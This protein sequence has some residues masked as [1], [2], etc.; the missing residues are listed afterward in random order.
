MMDNRRHFLFLNIG[1]FIDHFFL[2]IF[3]TAAA[4]SL[5]QEWQLSY[6]AL[7]P[8]STAGFVAFG[9]FSLPSG[10][11]ADRWSRQGMMFVFFV[12][13]GLSAIGTS[14]AQSPF[15][16]GLWLFLLG[17]F[18]SIY[19]PV[20]LALIARGGAKMGRDIA[21]NGVW[22]NMGVG[23][24]AFL[25]GLMIDQTGWRSAFWLP[26]LLSVGVG[27]LYFAHQKENI[28]VPFKALNLHKTKTKQPE[29]S[30]DAF[31]LRQLI[32][33]VS[34]VIFFTTAISSVIFQGTTFA[35]PKI[36]E[37]RLTGI[38][39]S[40]SLIGSLALFVFAIASFAQIVVGRMLDSFGPKRVFLSV[41]AIQ[42]VFFT[43][44][45]GQ[46]DW[47][48]L[49][50]AL[51]FM[52]GAFGQIPINDYMVGKMAKSELRASIYGV[53]YVISFGVWAVVVPLIS[54]VHIHYG[55]DMLFY[56]LA[57]CAFCLLA[58][59]STLPRH[60]PIPQSG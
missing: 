60:L 56:I 40:A 12:G 54:F 9:L 5:A 30:A 59:I 17:L 31:V 2:L 49:F 29:A 16:M 37:E 39:S 50:I 48:A 51:F 47:L 42:L 44:F 19:H 4:L 27:V 7:I 52:L 6:G 35:L 13:I 41:A 22:G 11:L 26:G 46:Y 20:G 24:A 36:F 14:T 3:A 10:W 18:A 23:F 15:E 53:R 55:F 21:V 45:I 34:M 25:T 28:L 32:M 33:R 57:G 43:L 1:H 58:A 38:A 8:Y